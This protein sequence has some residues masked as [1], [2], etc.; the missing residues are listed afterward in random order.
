FAKITLQPGEEKIVRFELNRRDFA[1][2]DVSVHDWAVGPGQYDILVGGSSRNL[3]LK[4]TIEV[5]STERPVQRLTRN[6]LLKEF[7]IHPKGKAFYNELVEA[8][9]LGNPGS[10]PEGD[11]NLTAEEASAK[12]KADLAVKAFLD[13]MPVYK[14]C[15]F[16]EGRFP[17]ERLEAIFKRV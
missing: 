1:Y 2:Y 3:P 10:Q 7:A 15:A 6:S 8:F 13:D 12:Q 5:A 17:E 16:S 11:S 4:Q 14:V 9:G